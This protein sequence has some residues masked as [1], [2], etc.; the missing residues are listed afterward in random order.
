MVSFS[1]PSKRKISRMMEGLTQRGP[2]VIIRA[3]ISRVIPGSRL[4]GYG[5]S[6]GAA[7]GT[8]CNRNSAAPGPHEVAID[9]D[10]QGASEL[11]II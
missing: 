4:S 10:A 5:L 2:L 11:V 8:S 1:E 7:Q 9:T 3:S 6:A